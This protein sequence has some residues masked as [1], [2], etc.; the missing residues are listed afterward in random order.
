MLDY[1]MFKIIFTI[2]Y[3]WRYIY[4]YIY[5]YTYSVGMLVLDAQLYLTL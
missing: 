5:V 4:I 2:T 3:V 1:T